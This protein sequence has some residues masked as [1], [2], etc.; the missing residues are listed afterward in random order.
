MLS[1]R[2]SSRSR[3]ELKVGNVLAEVIVSVGNMPSEAGGPLFKHN[4][5]FLVSAPRTRPNRS[6]RKWYGRKGRASERVPSDAGFARTQAGWQARK[7]ANNAP[8]VYR[9]NDFRP[10]PCFAA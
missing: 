7:S 5:A 2:N 8:H 3:Q 10:A 6:L 9:C 4:E 1:A